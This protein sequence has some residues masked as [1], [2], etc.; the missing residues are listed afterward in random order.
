MG[1]NTGASVPKVSLEQWFSNR[2]DFISQRTLGNVW[3]HFRGGHNWGRWGHWHRVGAGQGMLLYVLQHTR[4]FSFTKNGLIPRVNSGEVEQLG[5][6]L[7][8]GKFAARLVPFPYNVSPEG[9]RVPALSLCRW[10]GEQK[11]TVQG[12]TQPGAE[13]RS[14]PRDPL[15]HSTM[16]P[17]PAQPPCHRMGG[18]KPETFQLGSAS[19]QPCSLGCFLNPA[20]LHV[21]FILL[22]YG[23]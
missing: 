9:S 5:T 15:P 18:G 4:C 14:Q 11:I 8:E 17:L 1:S 10:D 3:R 21:S 19:C 2:G 7:M 12:C 23:D 22:S 16:C 20:L 6:E 13:T